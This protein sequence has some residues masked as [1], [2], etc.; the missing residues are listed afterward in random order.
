MNDIKGTQKGDLSSLQKVIR[1]IWSLL[2]LSS[3]IIFIFRLLDLWFIHAFV[4]NI[5]IIFAIITTIVKWV[6][7]KNNWKSVLAGFISI[8][9]CVFLLLTSYQPGKAVLR[10][11]APDESHTVVILKTELPYVNYRVYSGKYKW[12]YEKKQMHL[13]YK[14]D[15]ENY[16]VRD[17]FLDVEWVNENLAIVSYATESAIEIQFQN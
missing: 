7:G 4:G 6:A 17:E 9:F 3:I 16:D 1:I 12:F 14:S 2:V 8:A 15:A 11:Q 10:S 13:L 5:I